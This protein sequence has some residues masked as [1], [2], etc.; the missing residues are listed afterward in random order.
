MVLLRRS[1]S[2]NEVDPHDP[3]RWTVT[4]EATIEAD[5]WTV[6]N[7]LYAPE[8]AG[9]DDPSVIAVGRLPGTG[10]GV[11]EI[12]YTLRGGG[13]RPPTGLSALVIEQFQPPTHLVFSSLD[14]SAGPR[15]TTELTLTGHAPTLTQIRHRISTVFAADVADETIDRVLG[16]HR[17]V[18]R[19][20][21]RTA[22]RRL[23]VPPA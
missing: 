9:L 11:G 12:Q 1:R 10:V 21:L 16:E 7:Y 23:A 6:W 17:S 2:A 8:T 3:R 5:I 19:G 15:R 20:V 14:A 18:I 4:E 13:G 22:Q